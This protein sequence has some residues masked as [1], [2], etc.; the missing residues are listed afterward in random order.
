MTGVLNVPSPHHYRGRDGHAI[1]TLILHYTAGIGNAQ[2]TARL[3]ADPKRK[4]SAHYVIGR[5]GIIVQCVD[6]SDAAWHAGD[7]GKSRFPAMF[8]LD[9]ADFVPLA[10]VGWAAK[11]VNCRSIGIE[12]CN[13]GW[14]KKGPNPASKST[15]WESYSQ[16]Q[17]D[18]LRGLVEQLCASVPT[19]K[20]VTG[21]QDVTNHKTL[22]K[23]GGKTDPGPAFPWRVLPSSLT[24]VMFDFE[25]DGWRKVP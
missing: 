13:R 10:E 15:L 25:S 12:L 22:G 4:A 5:D 23:T 3:F 19:L 6:L 24:R 16:L 20:W 17:I 8:Q 11:V 1:D 18:S 7:G 21:H 2:A 9:G 14:A